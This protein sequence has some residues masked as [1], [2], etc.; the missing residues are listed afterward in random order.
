MGNDGTGA[1]PTIPAVVAVLLWT[2]SA[3]AVLTYTAKAYSETSDGDG[4]YLDTSPP[5]REVPL[6]ALTKG[7]DGPKLGSPQSTEEI[8]DY[9]QETFGVAPS[10]PTNRN[11]FQPSVWGTVWSQGQHGNGGGAF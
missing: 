3:L 9:Y 2:A 5:G 11:R 10:K 4:S 6:S 7:I 8:L 1:D